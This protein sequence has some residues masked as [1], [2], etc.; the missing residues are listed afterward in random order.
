MHTRALGAGGQFLVAGA[1]PVQRAAAGAPRDSQVPGVAGFLSGPAGRP[2]ASAPDRDGLLAEGCWP[3]GSGGLRLADAA[4]SSVARPGGSGEQQAVG[5]EQGEDLFDG[6]VP[7]AGSGHRQL[8]LDLVA[9]AAA[10]FLPDQVAGL[11]Q[12]SDGAVGAAL[13][14]AQAAAMSRSRAPGSCA[15]HSSTRAWVVRKPQLA[16]K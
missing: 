5:G 4:G 16:M 11:G 2:A 1:R 7:G 10:V 3:A 8:G 15:M 13:G 14:D 12:V 6:G 9:V